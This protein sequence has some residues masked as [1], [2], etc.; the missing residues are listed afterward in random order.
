[1]SIAWTRLLP[2]GFPD[3]IS[4]DGKNYY[5]NLINALLEKGI[6]P[7]ITLYHWDLPQ[8]LQDL[9]KIYYFYLVIVIVGHAI[10]H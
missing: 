5:S 7:V 9:G 6:E 1:M 3:Y 2:T 10:L 4:E 8:S